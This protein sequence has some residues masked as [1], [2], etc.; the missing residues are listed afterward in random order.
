VQTLTPDTMTLDCHN[1]HFR[2]KGN[3]PWDG[4]TYYQLYSQTCMP[5]AWHQ[6]LARLAKSL[7]LVFFSTPYDTSSSDFLAKLKMPA[8]KIASFELTDIPFIRHVAKKK[9]PMLMSTGIATLAEI[10]DAIRACR[11]AGNSKLILLK[12]TSMYPTPLTELNLRHIQELRKHYGALVG[13]SD[14]TLDSSVSV[15]AVALGICVIEKHFTLDRKLGGPDAAFSMEPHEFKE[16]V[17]LIRKTE[18]MLGEKRFRLSASVKKNRQFCR[19]LFAVQDIKRHERFSPKNIRSIRPG[20]GLPPKYY[21]FILKKKAG[22][23]I[24]RGTP[25]AWSMISTRTH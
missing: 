21:D 3:T 10:D 11:S 7:G 23:D 8:Y 6:K 9:K 18:A 19:S 14:H 25:L 2:I 22:K 17:R 20:S 24:R 12:C 16:M 13:L 15:A 1:Q 4:Q 5:W